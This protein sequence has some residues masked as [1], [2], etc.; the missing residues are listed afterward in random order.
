MGKCANKG[1]K[2]GRHQKLKKNW[3]SIDGKE[4]EWDAFFN[5]EQICK[6]PF[7]VGLP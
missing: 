4:K 1:K 6:V 3:M 5:L 7:M 2:L